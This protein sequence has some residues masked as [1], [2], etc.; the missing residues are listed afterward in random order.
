MAPT[1]TNSAASASTE[2]TPNTAAGRPK[3]LRKIEAAK[4]NVEAVR[5]ER[6][7]PSSDLFA[8]ESI[9]VDLPCIDGELYS[10]SPTAHCMSHV[11][12]EQAVCGAPT[13]ERTPRSA[14]ASFT[15]SIGCWD[16]IMNVGCEIV[17]SWSPALK[18]FSTAVLIR[19]NA[20][21]V[22]FKDLY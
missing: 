14:F 20:M 9:A 1:A 15:V 3:T 7:V 11:Y 6:T 18:R 19:D 17:G 10:L 16:S 13:E 12:A 22:R 21:K 8:A 2:G 4:L 5:K